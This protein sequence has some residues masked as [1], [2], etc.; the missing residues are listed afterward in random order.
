MD[1]GDRLVEIRVLPGIDRIDASDWDACAAPE[2]VGPESI[3]GGR[4]LSPFTTHRFLLALEQSGSAIADEGWA[5][6]Q[7]RL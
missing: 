2:A 6:Q 1:G 5:P 7:A 4:T 3:A